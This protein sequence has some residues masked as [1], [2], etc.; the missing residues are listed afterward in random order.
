MSWITLSLRKQDLKLQAND[1]ELQDL[2][3]GREER[4]IQRNM[5]YQKA[6]IEA[7]EAADL[8]KIKEDY[9]KV[10]SQR[11]T[12]AT[13][14]NYIY[15][16]KTQEQYEKYISERSNESAAPKSSYTYGKKKLTDDGKEKN[17]AETKYQEAYDN[18][19]NNVYETAKETYQEQS[20]YIKDMADDDKED[21]EQEATEKQSQI[22]EERTIV[23]TQ[24]QDI[25]QE[26]SA[27]SEQINA[28]SQTSAIKFSYLNKV[29]IL[30][31]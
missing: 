17:S 1:Y 16:F 22:Q 6:V 4:T 14:G 3:L 29:Y 30:S 27:V 20:T 7:Q 18:W 31:C 11:P 15:Y 24:L 26:L 19:K 21:I 25:N 10:K 13:I 2:S 12:K 23:E 8:Q 5:A 9:K 28:D